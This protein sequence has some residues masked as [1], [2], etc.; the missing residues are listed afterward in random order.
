MSDKS[1]KSFEALVAK[2][3]TIL[4]ENEA[5]TKVTLDEE[6]DSPDGPRQ[7]DVVIRSTVADI[8]LITVVEVRD[9][10]KNLSITHVDGLH[11]K[12]IDVNANK[13][14]LVARKGFSSGAKKK[15][16]RLGV[17]LCTAHDLKNI[18]E[19]VP[20]A[21]V[22]VHSMEFELISVNFNLGPL[23]R[24]SS[25]AVDYMRFMLDGVPAV[26]V[27]RKKLAQKDYTPVVCEDQEVLKILQ[28]RSKQIKVGGKVI[29]KSF[30]DQYMNKWVPAEGQKLTYSDPRTD[31]PVEVSGL[32][33]SFVMRY[34]FYFG[35]LNDLPGSFA[36]ESISSARANLFFL[37]EELMKYEQY[38]PQFSR[39]DELPINQ[40]V[41]I[42]SVARPNFESIPVKTFK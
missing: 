38:F 1:G 5:N 36:L 31:T 37:E 19:F 40:A 7:F 6:L 2:I 8:S 23:R 13:A 12:M 34:D 33:I 25:V 42:F 17:D 41:N 14:I 27:F 35:Y 28:S 20:K 3:Y 15:A 26:D 11:S 18:E 10:N 21:P 32:E 22:V 29:D 30:L 39:K 16:K 9:W 24:M 4:S